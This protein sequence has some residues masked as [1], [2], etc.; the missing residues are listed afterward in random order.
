MD[1][2]IPSQKPHA[3]LIE[4]VKDRAGHDRRYSI[5]PCKISTELGWEPKYSFERGIEITVNWYINNKNWFNK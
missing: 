1:Q 2:K 3:R 5:D 4:F